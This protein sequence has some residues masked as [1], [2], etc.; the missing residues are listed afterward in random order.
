MLAQD[1]DQV[2]EHGAQIE[3]LEGNPAILVDERIDFL[4]QAVT[5]DRA[6]ATRVQQHLGDLFRVLAGQ[7]AQQQCQ[8]IDRVLAPH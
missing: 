2:R 3:V 6:A 1:G 4:M 8:L 5:V 7:T